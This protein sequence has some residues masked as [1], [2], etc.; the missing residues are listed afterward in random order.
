M[1][2]DQ[3][4]LGAE[5]SQHCFQEVKSVFTKELGEHLGETGVEEVL[6]DHF[7]EVPHPVEDGLDDSG[8]KVGG[9][10]GRGEEG[11]QLG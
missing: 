4:P 3:V 1:V 8:E 6:V 2:V 7:I 9:E 11:L 10:E 5:M